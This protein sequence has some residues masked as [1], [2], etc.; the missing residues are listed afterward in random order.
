MGAEL[1]VLARR[2]A[3]YEDRSVNDFLEPSAIDGLGPITSGLNALVTEANTYKAQ[4]EAYPGELGT[5][6]DRMYGRIAVVGDRCIRVV[7]RFEKANELRRRP[8]S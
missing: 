5:L 2:L 7:D 6:F 3:P 1:D 4:R 8:R